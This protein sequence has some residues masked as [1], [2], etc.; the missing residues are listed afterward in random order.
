MFRPDKIPSS[1]LH[2]PPAALVHHRRHNR[3]FRSPSRPAFP[4]SSADHPCRTDCGPNHGHKDADICDGH[5]DAMTCAI[6][7]AGPLP[8]RLRCTSR[9]RLSV[10]LAGPSLRFSV[11][12]NILPCMP[13]SKSGAPRRDF[14][15]QASDKNDALERNLEIFRRSSILFT[16]ACPLKGV[17]C[18]PTCEG[19]DP[20]TTERRHA[21]PRALCPRHSG[22]G[23][24]P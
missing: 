16:T 1:L 11:C 22:L 2:V 23:A 7:H 10:C 5:R 4:P 21:R 6:R 8:R 9:L 19:F 20:G 3:L 17:A 13:L 15:P 24:G 18:R 12:F 14:M